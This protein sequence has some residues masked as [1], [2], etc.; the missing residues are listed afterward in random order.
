METIEKL[1]DKFIGVKVHTYTTQH[2]S[3]RYSKVRLGEFN[4][5]ISGTIESIWRDQESGVTLVKCKRR[6]NGFF[7]AALNDLNY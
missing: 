2:E 7:L 6:F 5:R 1:K 4:R 3:F